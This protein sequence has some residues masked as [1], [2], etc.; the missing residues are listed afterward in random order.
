[1]PSRGGGGGGQRRRLWFAD[2]LANARLPPMR[3]RAL[4]TARLQWRDML[5]AIDPGK[6]YDAGAKHSQR[7]EQADPRVVPAGSSLPRGVSRSLPYL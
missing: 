4:R 6:L 1:M 3:M 5:P 2:L 7:R